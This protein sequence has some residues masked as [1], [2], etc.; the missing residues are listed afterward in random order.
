MTDQVHD[1]NNFLPKLLEQVPELQPV[2]DKHIKEGGE[3]SPYFLLP[4]VA[5]FIYHLYDEISKHAEESKHLQHVLMQ[6]L[7]TLE[8]GALISDVD[9]GS[10]IYLGFV[11]SF[12]PRNPEEAPMYPELKKLMG[13]VLRADL[14][15]DEKQR[16]DIFTR[17]KTKRR[18]KKGPKL[19]GS[20][21]RRD[22]TEK[23]STG[24]VV[25][26][27]QLITGSP[28]NAPF[29]RILVFD[30][31]DGALSGVMQCGFCKQTYRFDFL[32]WGDG[33]DIRVMSLGRLPK[34]TL[35]TLARTIGE[36]SECTPHW[37][38]WVA[39]W[40]FPSETL[41]AQTETTVTEMLA[42]AEPP[43]M[44]I[45]TDPWIAQVFA[46]RGLPPERIAAVDDWFEVLQL[47]GG[48]GPVKRQAKD[49]ELP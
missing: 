35:E 2:Y 37:P 10:L 25:C 14:K 12:M 1:Y 42:R 9:L 32:D 7:E 29:T 46:A 18:V 16:P 39:P 38:V 31:Y 23:V 22:L 30:Y 24:S 19:P 45:A 5:R 13:H 17:V 15:Q 26:C 34:G 48:L 20:D 8:A 44:V 40:Q 28:T 41:K 6:I 21:D 4:E 47:P 49:T 3:I 27:Q 43:E 36:A 33:Q 11:E